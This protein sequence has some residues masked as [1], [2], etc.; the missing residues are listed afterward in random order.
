[1]GASDPDRGE[2][3]GHLAGCHPH[4]GKS[5]VFRVYWIAE[6]GTTPRRARHIVG[7]CEERPLSM[8]IPW[9]SHR[10]MTN[11]ESD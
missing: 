7:R 9:R 10:H 1:M 2:M 11:H 4:D 3:H 5:F 6:R 8:T